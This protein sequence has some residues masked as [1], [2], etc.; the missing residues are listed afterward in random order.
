LIGAPEA[1]PTT[2][3]AHDILETDRTLA[4]EVARSGRYEITLMDRPHEEKGPLGIAEARIVL[5]DVDIRKAVDP[6]ATTAVFTTRL[7][8]GDAFLKTWLTHG[9]TGES[10][11]AKYMVFRYVDGP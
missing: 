7:E 4:V 8:A 9:R 5:G 11:D 3:T 1:N 6:E 2:L 10:R